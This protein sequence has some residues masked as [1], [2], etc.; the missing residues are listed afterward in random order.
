MKRL[1]VCALL[2]AAALVALA[3]NR[4]PNPPAAGSAQ[5]AMVEVIDD[6]AQI[7][8]ARKV[9]AQEQENTF[10]H[11]LK[12]PLTIHVYND[13]VMALLKPRRQAAIES[14]SKLRDDPS[15]DAAKRIHAIRA[16]KALDVEPDANQLAAMAS[17]SPKATQELLSYLE[18]IYPRKTVPPQPLRALVIAGIDSADP[19]VRRQAGHLVG[20]YPIPEAADPLLNRLRHDPN[21]EPALLLGAARLRPNNEVLDLIVARLRAASEGDRYWTLMALVEF[22][23]SV[24]DPNLRR[25]ATDACVAHL[26]RVPNGPSIGT[27]LDALHLIAATTPTQSAKDMLVDLVRSAKHK[28]VRQYALGELHRLDPAGAKALSVVSG[29]K[30]PDEEPVPS[31]ADKL[32]PQQVADI[33]VR[34]RLLNQEEADR[35]LA[36]LKD[37]LRS[38]K[39]AA[40]DKD[41]E[42]AAS[43]SAVFAL[44]DAAGRFVG[45]DVETSM[46]PNRHDQLLLDFGKSSA[47]H[48]KPEAPHEIFTPD[49]PDSDTGKYQVQFIHGGKL[50]RF[51]PRDLGDWYDVAAVLAAVNGACADAGFAD[52]FTLLKAGDQTAEVVFA[53]PDRLKS[54][55]PQLGLELSS[56]PDEARRLGKAYEE[57]VTGRLKGK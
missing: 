12:E 55:A 57:G 18:Q 37:D 2:M 16:L 28:L 29:I 47:G 7:E 24:P 20:L 48:F 3:C 27:E 31:A 43:G 5:S 34:H 23:K 1:C 4:T 15:V 32:T 21:A 42:N 49:K 40:V 6:P 8:A 22:A 52:R 19:I 13:E 9:F 14:L 46:S 26:K 30:L 33:C 25:A 10:A 50:Y 17:S 38:S 39:N 11:V 54:A 36:T 45:F 41:S 53:D 35:A 56:D 44:L 51:Y